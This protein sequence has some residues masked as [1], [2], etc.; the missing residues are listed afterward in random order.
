MTRTPLVVVSA[1][2]LVGGALVYLPVTPAVGL[3]AAPAAIVFAALG[4]AQL[5]I[6][7]RL[8]ARPDRVSAALGAASALGFALVWLATR[9]WH[10]APGPDPWV[11][12][13]SVI[14]FTDILCLLLE[15]VAGGSLAAIAVPAPPETPSRT[16]PFVRRAI[17]ILS[18]VPVLVVVLLTTLLGVLAS[19]DG[20]VGAG[21]PGGTAEPRGLPPGQMSTVEYCRPDG[22]PLA[23]DLYLPTIEARVGPV[24]PIAVYVHGG[25]PWGDRNAMGAGAVL[26]NHAGALFEPIR[27]DL[28]ARGFVVA[29]IDYRLPPGTPWPAPIVDA[30]CA[31]RFLRAHA[32]DLGI[33]PDKIGVWGS[34]AGGNLASLLGL[35]EPA[36]GFDEGEYPD[37]SSAVQAV[38][39]MFGPADLTDTADVSGFGQLVLQVTFGGSFETR[40]SAS[41]ITY[42]SPNGPPFL[43]LQ[44]GDDPLTKP[45]QSARFAAALNDAG[46]PA[47]LVDVAGAGHTLNAANEQPGADQ[48]VA[49]V[50][51]FFVENLR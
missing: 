3:Y 31:V 43:I 44:G 22:V 38:V 2:A 47:T 28:T 29:A 40:R 16:R 34:S 1:L 51:Q 30:K 19:T 50:V 20:F 33:D 39:D 25:G 48:L 6:G 9:L 12:L 18:L 4:A 13:D 41:P 36:A 42:V 14:G 11:P 24:A 5:L 17:G 49:G 35:A 46:I 23:M 7:G 10:V 15:V 27:R 32:L 45:R 21:F 37:Q 8:L 26:A